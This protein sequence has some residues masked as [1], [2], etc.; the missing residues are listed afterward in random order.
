MTACL[1]LALLALGASS[2]EATCDSG[3]CTNPSADSP[4]AGSS[5]IQK[6][7][8]AQ[9]QPTA[10]DLMEEDELMEEAND[11]E[12]IA[13]AEK[14]EQWQEHAGKCKGCQK[15]CMVHGKCYT[16]NPSGKPATEAICLHYNGTW[17]DSAPTCGACTDGC[18]VKG[19]CYH[20]TPWGK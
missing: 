12:L 15:G 1:L 3:T 18:I 7:D 14:V 11:D 16:Q 6:V 8:V 20:K 10:L 13:L 9:R 2:P 19:Q 17:C 5:M 4:V